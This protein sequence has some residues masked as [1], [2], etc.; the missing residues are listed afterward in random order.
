M[1]REWQ[2]SAPPAA[3]K[4]GPFPVRR[5][6][7][8]TRDTSHFPTALIPTCHDF[9][10]TGPAWSASRVAARN[11]PAGSA[12]RLALLV[13]EAVLAVRAAAAHTRV[14]ANLGLALVSWQWRTG[15]RSAVDAAVEA[16]SGRTARMCAR[17]CRAGYR[18]PGAVGA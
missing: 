11:P 18:G 9:V 6:P 10:R 7:P 1:H 3:P 2:R 4:R 12:R 13:V 5:P 8:G 16:G 17:A 14:S 15:E